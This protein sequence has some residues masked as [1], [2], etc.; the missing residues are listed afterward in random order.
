M[1]MYNYHP[2][3]LLIY[4]PSGSVCQ[5]SDIRVFIQGCSKIVLCIKFDL[6]IHAGVDH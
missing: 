3:M 2:N 1:S 6:M 5:Q 4:T